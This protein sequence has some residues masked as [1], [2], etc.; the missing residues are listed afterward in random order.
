MGAHVRNGGSDH[1]RRWLVALAI[2]KDFMK[3]AVV[4]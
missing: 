3:T 1:E 4:V 2:I